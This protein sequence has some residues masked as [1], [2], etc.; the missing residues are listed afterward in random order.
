VFHLF[1][2]TSRET[3]WIHK[4]QQCR[5]LFPSSLHSL[6]LPNPF[7]HFP[8]LPLPPLSVSASLPSAAPLIAFTLSA[9]PPE[10]LTADPSEAT[11]VTDTEDMVV[12][13]V[14]AVMTTRTMGERTRL[15]WWWRRRGG[16]WRACRR[17]WRRR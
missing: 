14:A 4:T 17:T 11:A 7:P 16:R 9:P 3:K 1:L 5:S 10:S 13:V 8:S 6:P 2:R 12:T 15:Y